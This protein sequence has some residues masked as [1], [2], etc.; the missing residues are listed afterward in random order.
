MSI[1]R[2]LYERMAKLDQEKDIQEGPAHQNPL[3]T[4]YGGMKDAK[5]TP[6]MQAYYAKLK[7]NP[8]RP[9]T[10]AERE[11]E[12]LDKRESVELDELKMPAKD[13][14]GNIKSRKIRSAF[15]KGASKAQ[16]AGDR[17]MDKATS[18]DS[19][20]DD[21]IKHI[22]RSIAA[23]DRRDDRKR[24]ARKEEVE[25]VIEAKVGDT[26]HLGH[27]S[28][29]GSGVKGKVVKIDG[30]N[31]HIKNDKGAMFKGPM[32]RV[33]VGEAIKYDAAHPDQ[34]ITGRVT[35]KGKRDRGPKGS[36][37]SGEVRTKYSGHPAY[38]DDSPG[39][40]IKANDIGRL[41]KTARKKSTKP[42]DSRNV[43]N[44]RL[45]RDHVEHETNETFDKLTP[46][47]ERDADRRLKP[48]RATVSKVRL[49][50][51]EKDVAKS[52]KAYQSD[53]AGK[54]GNTKQ[55]KLRDLML[56]GRKTR[57]EDVEVTESEVNRKDLRFRRTKLTDADE[58]A[59]RDR[60][61]QSKTEEL[62][63]VAEDMV[64]EAKDSYEVVAVKGSKVVAKMPAEKMDIKDAVAALTKMHGGAD[65]QVHKNGKIVKMK[66]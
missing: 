9:K 59:R 40:P 47:Q 2:R 25:Q 31:V 39:L 46:A 35:G 44:P 20:I 13:A 42:Y 53:K 12:R 57:T 66:G 49:R 24:K 51:G 63:N 52:V 54:P 8:S 26:V 38:K 33:T 11:K 17:S 3:K 36:R 18:R 43:R 56:K 60:E 15:A 5:N 16:A 19:G 64:T 10:A 45:T 48:T 41:L 22:D 50:A 21:T 55:R 6:S 1:Q 29:G 65:V 7:K 34:G 4:A 23:D 28:K 37:T 14:K 30:R 61:R 32:D 62:L 58:R 27:A